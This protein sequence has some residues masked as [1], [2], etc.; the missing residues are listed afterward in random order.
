MNCTL[1]ILKKSRVHVCARLA[2]ARARA[3]ALYILDYIVLI[4]TQIYF[5]SV[6]MMSFFI[7]IFLAVKKI[8]I[9][10]V[11]SN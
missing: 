1:K 8:Y 7:G 2:C 5:D 3:L 9:T 4:R 11:A 10:F 6:K